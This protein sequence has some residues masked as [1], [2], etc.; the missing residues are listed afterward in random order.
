[1][2]NFMS[3]KEYYRQYHLK[4]YTP[5]ERWC[6]TCKK[7]LIGFP[8]GSR[9]C[10]ACFVDCECKDCG[11]LFKAKNQ[12]FL[13]CSK[14]AYKRYK[15]KTPEKFDKAI[16]NYY[17]KVAAK[18]RLSKNLPIDHVFFNGPRSDGYLNKKG[19]RLLLVKGEEERKYRRVYEHVLVIESHLKRK[20]VKGETVH[21]KNGIR[22]DNRIEN[23]ELWSKAQPAGQRVEDRISF[24]I[25]FLNRYGYTVVKE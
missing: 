2:R 5:K 18:R 12:R 22:D 25:E 9:R 20:L 8:S 14:C 6:E 7:S 4:N 13:R 21:H 3:K 24:Y 1:M 19:Y 16:G 15:E 17:K 11:R 10:P 23:L